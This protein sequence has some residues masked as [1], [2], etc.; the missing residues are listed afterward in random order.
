MELTVQQVIDFINE[1][2]KKDKERPYIYYTWSDE[3][4]CMVEVRIDM[5]EIIKK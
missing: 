5:R 2:W 4:Q 3:H 1:F